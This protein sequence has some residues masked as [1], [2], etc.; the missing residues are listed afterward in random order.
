MDDAQTSPVADEVAST[1][2]AV[3]TSTNDDV[4]LEDIE[5]SLDDIE[6]DESEE[7]APASEESEESSEEDI[8]EGED[9]TETNTDESTDESVKD[10]T[11]EDTDSVEAIKKQNQEAYERRQAERQA[12]QEADRKAQEE[13][14][15]QAAD[16]DDLQKRKNFIESYNLTEARITLNEDAIQVGIDKAFA[17]IDL[18]RDKRYS[19]EFAKALDEFEQVYMVRDKNGRPVE[20][21]KDVFTHLQDK[22]D[23][24]RRIQGVGE[25]KG[26][27]DEVKQKAKTLLPPSRTPKEAKVDQDIADF[28]KAWDS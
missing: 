1:P 27:Q 28:D 6:D 9:T 8:S 25:L 18:M 4:E 19:E 12:R 15:S 22:A 7:E 23:S 20:V 24:I 13:Y 10:T 17:S 5:I 11:E 26:K 16:E 3:D 2:E 21:R 14:L